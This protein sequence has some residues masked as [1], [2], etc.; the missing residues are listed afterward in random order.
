MTQSNKTSTI[1][2]YTQLYHTNH[3]D[4]VEQ[5]WSKLVMGE[6]HPTQ[7]LELRNRTFTILLTT[8]AI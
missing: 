2:S 8:T 7:K 4:F 5:R 1:K 3:N 6:N